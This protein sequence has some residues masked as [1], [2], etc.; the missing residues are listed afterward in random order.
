MPAAES[1]LICRLASW[2][3]GLSFLTCSQQPMAFCQLS[4]TSWMWAANL[5]KSTSLVTA[6]TVST[7]HC[8][9]NKHPGLLGRLG[10]D[11]RRPDVPGIVDE[12]V[13]A[14]F[15]GVGV[16]P[17]R[18]SRFGAHQERLILGAD[19]HSYLAGIAIELASLDPPQR[20][21]IHQV[22]GHNLARL[23]VHVDGVVEIRLEG[24]IVAGLEVDLCPLQFR[25]VR[26]RR[27]RRR[28]SGNQSFKFLTTRGTGRG[29][30]ILVRRGQAYRDNRLQG[31]SDRGPPA[32]R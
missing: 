25:F 19:Q 9:S 24:G 6:W 10:R 1:A 20:L 32:G 7:N 26:V 29:L 13:L 8:A 14:Q 5:K 21:A 11:P 17:L 23:L 31:F 3:L 30:I 27:H 4:F 28:S 2:S 12:R 16:I 22:V 18:S 15:D